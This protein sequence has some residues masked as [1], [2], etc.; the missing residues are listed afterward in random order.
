VAALEGRAGAGGVPQRRAELCVDG[1]GALRLVVLL[2]LFADSVPRLFLHSGA[3][4]AGLL[5][6][7]SSG[8]SGGGGGGGFLV[9]GG[10]G[11]GGL[12]PGAYTRPLLS[13]T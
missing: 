1:D 10:G 12:L 9:L 5:N 4:G 3:G 2:A 13:S 6:D 8:G 11:R 7:G